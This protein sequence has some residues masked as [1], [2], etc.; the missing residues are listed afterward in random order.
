MLN[1]ELAKL[2][3]DAGFPQ[4][5]KP[6]GSFDSWTI[7]ERYGENYYKTLEGEIIKQHFSP[8]QTYLK[9]LVF[10][11]TLSELIEACGEE[12]DSLQR[13]NDDTGVYYWAKTMVSFAIGGTEISGDTPEEA[14]AKLW[15]ELNK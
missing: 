13:V 6:E 10:I 12:F 5:D 1:Y 2:L 8:G 15:I 14:V 3:K 11:P 4:P 9:E 7:R